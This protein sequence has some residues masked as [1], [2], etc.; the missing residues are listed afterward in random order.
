MANGPACGIILANTGTPD[1][2]TPHAVATYLRQFLSDP[3]V[4]SSNRLAWWFVLRFIVIPRRKRASAEKYRGIWTP[5]GS[6]ILV[7]HE[8][9]ARALEAQFAEEVGPGQVVVRF[10]MNYGKPTIPSVLKELRRMG[11]RKL[12][13]VPTYPQAAY[14]TTRAVAHTVVCSLHRMRWK[15]DY[16]IVSNYH[17]NPSYARAIAASVLNAGFDPEGEDRLLLSFHSIPLEHIEDGDTYEHEAGAS[18]LAVTDVLGLDRKRW[19]IGYQSPFGDP[20][21]WLQPYSTDVLKRWGSI[22]TKRAFFVC[23]GF[24]ADCLETLYDIPADLEPAFLDACAEAG[25]V[26]EFVAIPCLGKTKAHVKVMADV[27]RP[28]VKEALDA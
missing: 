25:Y 6:P 4:V 13:I 21:Q 1:A 10:A 20:D 11:V 14:S 3:N 2:P 9:L 16:E 12:V 23:P 19:T 8:A 7:Q 15:P 28:I 27:V 17:R 22:G 5:E 24:A 18:A 26:G